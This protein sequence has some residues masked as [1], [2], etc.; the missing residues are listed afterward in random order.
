[1]RWRRIYQHQR[2]LNFVK[3]Y[4]V[5]K[6]DTSNVSLIVTI[7]MYIN[8]YVYLVTFKNKGD[9]D[10][11]TVYLVVFLRMYFYLYSR[12]SVVY[13][14]VLYPNLK[15][16][17]QELWSTQLLSLRPTTWYWSYFLIKLKSIN[18]SFEEATIKQAGFTSAGTTA[19]CTTAVPPYEIR[20]VEA[21]CLLGTVRFV[22]SYHCLV[23]NFFTKEGWKSGWWSLN[24][25][26]LYSPPCK[27]LPLDVLYRSRR[28]DIP[29][30][31]PCW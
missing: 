20:T 6:R 7:Y 30:R 9:V 19:A 17:F 5:S 2:L 13:V 10:R 16:L 1:M 22:R 18:C 23:Q 28:C 25:S 3:C 11:L 26:L 27:C 14:T 12:V 15:F 8:I 29:A 24:V 21:A 4:W 31:G